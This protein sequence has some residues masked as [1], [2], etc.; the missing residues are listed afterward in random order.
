MNE[1]LVLSRE[2]R[3]SSPS[4]SSLRLEV[5]APLGQNILAVP[6]GIFVFIPIG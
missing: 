1:K 5:R 6:S 4:L 3:E 2:L